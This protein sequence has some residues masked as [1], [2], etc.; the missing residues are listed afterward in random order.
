LKI[1]F[2]I[3][4]TIYKY[5]KDQTLSKISDIRECEGGTCLILN[6]SMAIE[7]KNI[8][9]NVFDS[10]IKNDFIKKELKLELED[11]VYNTHIEDDKTFVF[12]MT[13]EYFLHLID[14]CGFNKVYSLEY[15]LYKFG[16]GKNGII[17]DD[18]LLLKKYESEDDFRSNYLSGNHD[19]IYYVNLSVDIYIKNLE[20]MKEDL[21]G[22][23]LGVFSN[24]VKEQMPEENGIGINDFISLVNEYE[25]F[26]LNDN[27]SIRYKK[28][29]LHKYMA[30]GDVFFIS[31]IGVILFFYL[32]SLSQESYYSKEIEQQSA[33]LIKFDNLNKQIKQELPRMDFYTFPLENA[34]DVLVPFTKYDPTKYTYKFDIKKKKINVFMIVNDIS[35]VE[36]LVG[37]LKSKK[38]KFSYIKKNGYNFE[39]KIV[40]KIKDK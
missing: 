14:G 12:G 36:D 21:L 33:Q 32:K 29:I 40:I 34:K 3:N 17:S 23:N 26:F 38:Y 22:M 8:Y 20:R 6:T 25:D 19:T 28:Q 16:P 2:D 30:L 13:K 5:E 37:F 35:N 15:F 11:Y 9:T 18:I 24:K 39:F 10:T 1:Y 7:D 31:V 27:I 4:K